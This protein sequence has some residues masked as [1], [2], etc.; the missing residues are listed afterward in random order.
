[1]NQ[2]EKQTLAGQFERL[3]IAWQALVRAFKRANWWLILVVL[4]VI[5]GIG[6]LVIAAWA[7]ETH[8]WLIMGWNLVNAATCIINFRNLWFMRNNWNS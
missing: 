5:A 4:D 3:H 2:I 1:M 8:E 7:A 6:S